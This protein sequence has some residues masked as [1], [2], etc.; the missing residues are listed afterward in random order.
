MRKPLLIGIAAILVALGVFLVLSPRERHEQPGA[1]AIPVAVPGPDKVIEAD[2]DNNLERGEQKEAADAGLDLHEDTRDETPPGVTPAQIE[3]GQRAT[4]A[5]AKKEL[6]TPER[7][8]GAQNYSCRSRPVVNQ[9]ALTQRRVGVALHFTVS[10]PGSLNAIFGLFNRSS[11][12]ASSN[13][14]F[15]PVSLKCERWVPENRKAWCQLA[16]NSAYVCIEIMTKDRSRASW[17]ALPMFKNG[18]LAA[19]VRDIARRY[20]APLKHVDPKG[21]VWTPG[22]VDHD[23]LECGNNHWDVGKNFPWDVF[24]RQ[25]QRGASPAPLTAAQ[26]K[27]C[28]LLNFHRSRAHAAGRWTPER[29]K[30]AGELKRL[31]PSGRCLSR[32]R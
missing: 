26:R 6:V 22:I 25:V 16:A 19:L 10:D 5:L 3:A 24:M 20:G 27:A 9:S 31:V 28:S 7:P 13:Y 32:Y 4:D 29:A 17:L 2:R 11:F 23:A 1:V 8:G 18:T 14:G 21:C 30:R 12:G 15:E